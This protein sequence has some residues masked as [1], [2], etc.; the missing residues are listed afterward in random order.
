ME[1][2]KNLE[3]YLAIERCNM[4]APVKAREKSKNDKYTLSRENDGVD[5]KP[6]MFSSLGLFNEVGVDLIWRVAKQL[7]DKDN[8]VYA[9][10]VYRITFAVIFFSQLWHPMRLRS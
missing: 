9:H 1:D 4:M 10:C 5:F 6:F 3:Y 7:S 2:G 8:L